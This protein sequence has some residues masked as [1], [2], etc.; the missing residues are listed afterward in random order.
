MPLLVSCLPF[1]VEENPLTV[2]A[3]SVAASTTD[4]DN[5][6]DLLEILGSASEK[7]LNEIKFW[8][9]PDILGALRFQA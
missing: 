1:L 3:Q 4:I 2:M 6:V 5:K 8:C 7:L 9:F